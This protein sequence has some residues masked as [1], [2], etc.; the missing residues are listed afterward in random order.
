MQTLLLQKQLTALKWGSWSSLLPRC[1]LGEKL[2]PLLGGL[3]MAVP[4]HA[5]AC[6]HRQVLLLF[7]LYFK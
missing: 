7:P 1:C 5:D 3:L 6:V 2:P 4:A